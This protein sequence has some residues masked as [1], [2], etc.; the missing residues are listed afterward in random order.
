ME[1][2]RVRIPQGKEL[3]SHIAI[4]IARSKTFWSDLAS[5]PTN[6]EGP[7]IDTGAL[8][9]LMVDNQVT[10]MEALAALLVQRESALVLPHGPF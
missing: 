8:L 3:E 10:I 2:I 4:S 9:H 5:Q 7:E 6:G 1:K